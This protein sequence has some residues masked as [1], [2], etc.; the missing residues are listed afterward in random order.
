M[1]RLE[2]SHAASA[3]TSD[4][5]RK[6]RD[7]FVDLFH[8]Q[9]KISV[10][11]N[12]VFDQTKTALELA[13]VSRDVEVTRDAAQ[14]WLGST[15]TIRIHATYR[16]KAGFDLSR[17]FEVTVADREVNIKVPRAKIL[18]VEPLN[19][20][21]EELKNGL[22]NKIQPQDVERELQRMQELARTKAGSL[23]DDAERTF[24]RLLSEKLGDL[25]VQ[26][27]TQP[28]TGLPN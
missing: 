26:I 21:V 12:V 2:N 4:A 20:S 3:Q 17:N 18:T 27:Q 19:I 10:N 11:E 24:K 1:A 5:A 8:L 9:P 15:K 13:V 23:S 7:A 16:V 6:I 14:T 28:D 22:W 25:S